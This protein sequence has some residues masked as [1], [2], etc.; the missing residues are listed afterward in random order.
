MV[1]T[2]CAFPS[3]AVPVLPYGRRRIVT[4]CVFYLPTKAIV[5]YILLV[6]T[7]YEY[8]AAIVVLVFFGIRWNFVPS[9]VRRFLFLWCTQGR[10]ARGFSKIGGNKKHS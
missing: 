8:L 10:R 1:A 9:F 4:Q 6:Y 3:A 7:K 2:E 5:P